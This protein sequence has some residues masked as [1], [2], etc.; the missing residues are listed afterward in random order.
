MAMQISVKLHTLLTAVQTVVTRHSPNEITINQELHRILDRLRKDPSMPGMFQASRHAITEHIG[1]ALQHETK[2]TSLLETITPIAH[3]LPWRRADGDSGILSR[4]ARRAAMADIIGPLA[5][6]R[7][8]L[9]SLGLTLIAPNTLCPSHHHS[10]AELAHVVTGSATW[11]INGR[12]LTCHA[13]TFIATPPQAV[14]A[15]HTE[16]ESLLAL[17]MRTIRPPVADHRAREF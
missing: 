9:V 10:D 1:A 13:G 15:T 4:S 12:P 2:L 11:V 6:F 17:Y 3:Y 16:D 14:H 7:S 5:P 8:D